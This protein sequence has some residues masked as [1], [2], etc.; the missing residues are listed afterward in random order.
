M[1]G[2]DS[3][4]NLDTPGAADLLLHFASANPSQL[5][6]HHPVEVVSNAT[7]APFLGEVY[8]V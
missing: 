2:P 7:I 4:G 3:M 5:G 8:E 6:S 1:E